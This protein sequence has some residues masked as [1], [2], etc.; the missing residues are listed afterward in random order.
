[1]KNIK[2]TMPCQDMVNRQ[3]LTLVEMMV[4]VSIF[5]VILGVMFSFLIGYSGSYNDT[6]DKVRF[7]Q[8]M[9]AVISLVSSEVRS[10]GCDPTQ[11]GFENFTVAST[12][13]MRCQMDLNGDADVTDNSPDEDILYSFDAGTGQLSRDD[14]GGPIVILRD[15][16]NLSFSYFDGTGGSLAA[17]PLNAVDRSLVRF[18]GITIDGETSSGEPVNYSTR[19]TIR[20][21]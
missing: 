6:R 7:Q 10:V 1:M 2:A 21:G 14:G 17:L 3:G 5:T 20:N 15:I 8:S 13:Q 16:Q 12:V 4:S 18:V 19:I 9:R 11:A